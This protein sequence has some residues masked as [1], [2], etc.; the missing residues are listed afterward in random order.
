[1]VM[2]VTICRSNGLVEE[3]QGMDGRAIG[4]ESG[5]GH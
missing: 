5:P 2:Y 4:I 3:F 1:M